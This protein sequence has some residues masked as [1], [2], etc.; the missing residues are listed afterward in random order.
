[1]YKVVN[2]IDNSIYGEYETYL[3]ALKIIK[4][5]YN[6]DDYCWAYEIEKD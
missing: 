4:E 5:L 2:T 3:E 1:M 6:F